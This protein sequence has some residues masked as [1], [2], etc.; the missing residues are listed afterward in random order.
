[1]H[2]EL[3]NELYIQHLS[4]TLYRGLWYNFSV[5]YNGTEMS[6]DVF[7]GREERFHML[8]KAAA[9]RE[10]PTIFCREKSP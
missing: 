6:A 5:W 9:R 2:Y 8:E 3:Y 7:F 10:L 1:M 4:L